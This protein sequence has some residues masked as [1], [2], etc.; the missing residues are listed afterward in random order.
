MLPPPAPAPTG[1]RRQPAANEL[2]R[3]AAMNANVQGHTRYN[4]SINTLSSVQ[5]LAQAGIL[6]AQAESNRRRAELLR[7]GGHV[8]NWSND[9]TRTTSTVASEAYE[10]EDNWS[11]IDDREGEEEANADADAEDEEE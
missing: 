11:G 4:P 10:S 8:R 9:S 6:E 3:L 1:P 5:L 2:A 7:S